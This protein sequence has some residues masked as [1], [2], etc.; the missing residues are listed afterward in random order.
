M[1]KIIL[2]SISKSFKGTVIFNNV[3]LTGETGKIIA[4]KGKS[5]VGKSTLLNIIAGLEKASSG[6]YRFDDIDMEKKNLNELAKVRGESI[7]YISQFSPMIPKLTTFENIC[8]PL[9]FN[10]KNGKL[11]ET[12]IKKIVELSKLFQ[13]HHLLDKKIKKLSGGEIQ[14]AG[15]I[16]SIICEPKL[17]VADEP[18]GS[19]DDETSSAILNFFRE[20]KTNGTTVILATHSQM[21]ADQSDVVY[22]LTKE[23]LH[24]E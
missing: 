20:M 15:I 19:L 2:K 24:L 12:K 1:S 11:E 14:R 9:I 13:V 7:G 8:I 21:V 4:I 18:T 5:G 10:K 3:N 17:V 16:R 23:G 6:S 22:N